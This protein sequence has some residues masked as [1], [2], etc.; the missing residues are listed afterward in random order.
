MEDID[1][2]D[3]AQVLAAAAQT[4]K[5][6]DQVPLQ[7]DDGTEAPIADSS[8]VNAV[9][10]ETPTKVAFAAGNY[11]NLTGIGQRFTQGVLAVT[12]TLVPLVEAALIEL[13]GN[14]SAYSREEGTVTA[15]IVG[16]TPVFEFRFS[17]KVSLWIGT[18]IQRD[19][20][21]KDANYVLEKVSPLQS[22]KVDECKI[23]TSTGVLTISG[24]VT[25]K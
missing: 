7:L 25:Q 20:V 3:G 15:K 14:S 5:L 24:T 22:A 6:D 4:D 2:K 19:A 11:G 8:E 13:T 23:D 12:N 1:G 21:L 17:Y 9:K 16:E 18:D 10:T